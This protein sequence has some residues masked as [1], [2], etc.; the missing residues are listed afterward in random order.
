[1]SNQSITETLSAYKNKKLSVTENITKVFDEIK[2]LDSKIKSFLSLNQENALNQAVE[3]EKR[4]KRG[5]NLPLFGIPIAVKDNFN[6]KQVRTTASS[7]VLDDYVP[8]YNATV[9]E[10]LIDAGA[11]V[12]GKTNMDAWAHGSSTETSDYFTTHNPWNLDYLPGG[13]S[14]GSAAAVSAGYVPIAL[15]SETAGSIR[16]PSSWCGVTGFKPS[17]G[18]TSRYGLISMCSSTDCPGPIANTAEECEMMFRVIAGSDPKDATSHSLNGL[19]TKEKKIIGLPRQYFTSEM[20]PEMI[21]AVLATK[22]IFK[23]LGYSFIDLDLLDPKYSISVY[24]IVQRSEVSSN[25]GRYDGIRYGNDRTRFGQEAKRRIMLGSYVLTTGYYDAYYLQAQKVRTLICQDYDRAFNQVDFLLSPTT[26]T[27]ALPIGSTKDGYMFGELQDILLE[28]SSL[29]GLTAISM[30]C[31]FDNKGLPC[32][33]QLVGPLD[34]DYRLL[35]L[36][37]NYQTLTDWHTRTPPILK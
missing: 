15:G 28:A 10:R 13:S 33:L 14:G 24:T 27:T 21:K 25:L 9:V 29:A 36:A 1:M 2:R 12:V 7:K 23:K 31:G 11:I 34:S 17:Y 20:N 19:V 8:E 16:Q 22:D 4:L 37:E 30:P 32:G 6:T 26:P 3:V 35:K 5:E 18:A